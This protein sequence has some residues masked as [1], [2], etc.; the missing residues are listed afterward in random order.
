M[1]YRSPVVRLGAP[2]FNIFELHHH[3]SPYQSC[4]HIFALQVVS[5]PFSDTAQ[6]A[7]AEGLRSRIGGI[8]PPLGTPVLPQDSVWSAA[9]LLET[10]WNDD[11]GGVGEGIVRVG[12]GLFVHL[13]FFLLLRFWFLV[14]SG[15]C[16][17]LKKC[18]HS[19][20]GEPAQLQLR[21]E[22]GKKEKQ[23]W[24]KHWHVLKS[25]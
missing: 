4:I 17:K 9:A 1:A 8:Q 6:D 15:F 25:H 20:T 24:V 21:G 22:F 2:P 18:G 12:G 19:R 16:G 11:R 14:T 5:C 7:H 3:V 10:I 13:D 23:K